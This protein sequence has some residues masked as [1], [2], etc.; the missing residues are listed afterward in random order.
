MTMEIKLNNHFLE[1]KETYLF[2]DIAKR[3]KQ[4]HENNPER[5]IIRMG[6]GD[7][8]LPL[9]A[10]ITAAMEDAV[11]EMSD[12]AS[13]HGYPPEYGYDFLRNAVSDHY[14]ELGVN[15]SPET[16]Y[17]S[18]GAKSDLGNFPDILGDN[19]VIIP[20]PVYPVYVDSNIMNGR[21]IS[22]VNGSKENDFLPAPPADRN[23][24]RRSR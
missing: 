24:R 21:K 18:D 10:S 15:V 5:E 4:F 8:T 12:K 22:F 19:P 16:V 13:F 3:V 9:P 20:D 1:V 6:I 17:V 14:K 7:V 23:R 2:S 11:K